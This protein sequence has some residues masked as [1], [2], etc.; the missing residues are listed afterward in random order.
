ML[1]NFPGRMSRL[2]SL[3]YSSIRF[4]RCSKQQSGSLKLLAFFT[5]ISALTVEVTV[6]TCLEQPP[7][8]RNGTPDR[9][10]ANNRKLSICRYGQIDFRSSGGL[11]ERFNCSRLEAANDFVACAISMRHK[12]G[13][14][15]VKSL[16][17]PLADATK[18]LIRGDT[19]AAFADQI[20]TA[21]SLALQ[22]GEF[23]EF[24][25][26]E[27]LLKSKLLL[28]KNQYDQFE[29]TL[30]SL[31]KRRCSGADFTN[32]LSEKG[33]ALATAVSG[34]A[35]CI[36]A[37]LPDAMG[38][39]GVSGD[40]MRILG[41]VDAFF[42]HCRSFLAFELDV[43]ATYPPPNLKAVRDA[44]RGITSWVIGVAERVTDQWS[45][46]VKELRKG[47]HQFNTQVEFLTPPQL[48]RALAELEK[49]NKHP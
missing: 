27:E 34:M 43:C 11:N 13:A 6:A 16:T 32:W 10:F 38:K 7:G 23:W 17:Q 40:A 9:R 47:S 15:Q 21:R 44:F 45:R 31:P 42:G 24:L 4:A 26:V 35:H 14:D 3:S 19:A 1:G 18:D 46:G 25:L 2:L 12:I 5:V 8:H 30:A 41:T 33:D 39:P 48:Q 28:L 49:I 29:R 36:N 22:H 20:E 37:D